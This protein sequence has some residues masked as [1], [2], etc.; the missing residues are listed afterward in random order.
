MKIKNSKILV[1]LIALI[2]SFTCFANISLADEENDVMLISE[3]GENAG[4]AVP[5]SEETT[6]EE[7]TQTEVAPLEEISGDYFE[8]GTNITVNKAIDGNAFII[9]NE[10]TVTGQIN[11]DLYVIA[12]TVNINEGSSVFGNIFALSTNF[13]MNGLAYGI[14]NA[15]QNF[16]CGYNGMVALDFKVIADNIKFNGFTE[17]G[18][19]FTANESL[20]LTDDAYICGNLVY[21]APGNSVSISE[22]AT[23]L[24]ETT[25]DAPTAAANVILSYVNDAIIVL[26]FGLII[27][28]LFLIIKPSGLKTIKENV[29]SNPLK[30]IGLGILGLVVTPIIVV[31][32][33]LIPTL[34]VP[35]LIVLGLYLIALAIAKVLAILAIAK[36]ANCKLKLFENNAGVLIYAVI[37]LLVFWAIDFIPI[38]N[39]IIALILTILG[40]GIITT[41]LVNIVSRKE[42][43]CGP[44]CDCQVE[45]VVEEIQE[46]TTIVEETKNE[47]NDNANENENKEEK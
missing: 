27:L 6:T 36:F 43:A 23:I 33:F 47:E 10:V 11:G 38:A 3:D 44:E 2:L 5:Y 37:L 46:E 13:N 1:I 31:I 4:E 12:S 25:A 42:C 21:T 8:T 14:Y 29:F 28:L 32:L 22:K 7:S 26:V 45:E 41:K 17:R 18:A 19:Y 16:D 35:A 39:I 34:A 40:L 20:T 24:G 15:T 9:G 30:T